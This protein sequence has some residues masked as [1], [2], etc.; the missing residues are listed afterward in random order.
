LPGSCTQ[1]GVDGVAVEG[2]G[3]DAVPEPVG[4]V[5]VLRQVTESSG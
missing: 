3:I 4:P 2:L 1:C 5:R